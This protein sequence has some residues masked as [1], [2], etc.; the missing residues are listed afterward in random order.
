MLL[1]YLIFWNA[2]QCTMQHFY[3]HQY[4]QIILCWTF[5]PILFIDQSL[6]GCSHTRTRKIWIIPILADS[7]DLYV[8]PW[9]EGLLRRKIISLARR[10]FELLLTRIHGVLRVGD[11]ESFLALDE[12]VALNFPGRLSHLECTGST[13]VNHR[14]RKITRR[15][16]TSHKS[17][18]IKQSCN[19]NFRETKVEFCS[20]YKWRWDLHFNSFFFPRYASNKKCQCIRCRTEYQL[21][22]AVLF[23]PDFNLIALIAF[24]GALRYSRWTMIDEEHE[25][26]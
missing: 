19:C 23:N 6:H 15:S 18:T 13:K 7:V 1:T 26:T 20:V 21:S 4:V 10:N 22:N 16:Q 3:I 8:T 9:T 5:F 12:H 11:G 14:T 17:S 24:R 2:V 25:G